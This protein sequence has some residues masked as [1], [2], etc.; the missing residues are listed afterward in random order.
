[1]YPSTNT[2]SV[3]TY[4][5]K[6]LAIFPPTSPNSPDLKKYDLDNIH[7]DIKASTDKH[8]SDIKSMNDHISDMKYCISFVLEKLTDTSSKTD[9]Q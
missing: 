2:W 3:P 5:N 1:M 9:K 6:T 8:H 7:A 4:S